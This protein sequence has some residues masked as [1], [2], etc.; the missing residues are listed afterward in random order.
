ML[1]ISRVD[2]RG[3]RRLIV[4][5]KLIPP[6]TAE[7]RTAYE[8]A[9]SDLEGRELVVDLKNLTIISREG[10]DLVIQLMIQGV[11]FRCGGLFA[12]WLLRQLSDRAR[13]LK[14]RP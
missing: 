11:Q 9:K 6:W 8:D 4:E 5:G 2:T 1:R 12:R 14:T 7:L 13:A 10:E 3:Q